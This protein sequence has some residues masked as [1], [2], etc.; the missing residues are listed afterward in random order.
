M[1]SDAVGDA[2]FWSAVALAGVVGVAFVKLLAGS[3]VGERIPGLKSL[4]TFL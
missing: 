3:E 4:G 1:R 2:L